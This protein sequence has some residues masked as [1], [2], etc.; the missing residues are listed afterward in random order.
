MLK[1]LIPRH[2]IDARKR[3]ERVSRVG[4]VALLTFYK[5]GSQWVRDLLTHRLAAGENGFT[6]AA[7]SSDVTHQEWPNMSA[8][9]VCGPIY[10][11]TPSGWEQNRSASDKAIAVLR[12]PRD[13]I[14]SRYY[15]MA[16]SHVPNT[17]TEQRRARLLATTDENRMLFSICEQSGSCITMQSWSSTN[18]GMTDHL[19]L[20]SYERLVENTAAEL[21][22][23]YQFLDWN[24]S[25]EHVSEI[26][27][28][29]S[30]ER[31]SGRNRGDENQ[32]S[33]YRKGVPGDWRKHF[34][35]MSGLA[36]ECVAPNLVHELGYED[37]PSWHNSLPDS[38]THQFS[39]RSDEELKSRVE[40]QAEVV[41]LRE[42]VRILRND[43]PT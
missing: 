22:A 8:G 12:D 28:E 41:R 24:V 10:S 7:Q 3:S 1:G 14:V 19:F 4:A 27:S 29:R 17:A 23:I 31:R 20:T 11:A 39:G 36:L 34:T 43:Q 15:S 38:Q 40:L 33:H 32:F 16:F 37:D 13:A 26:V 42:S 35:R 18:Y 5:S 21:T 30:F 6:N 2:I 9:Q 25:E